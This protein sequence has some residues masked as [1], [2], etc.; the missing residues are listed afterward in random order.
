[1]LTLN[2]TLRKN[3]HKIEVQLYKALSVVGCAAMVHLLLPQLPSTLGF[4]MAQ[5]GAAPMPRNSIMSKAWFWGSIG[6]ANMIM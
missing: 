3:H 2:L 1:M 4:R 6:T 5:F